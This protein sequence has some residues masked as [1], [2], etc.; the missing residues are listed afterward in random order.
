[1]SRVELKQ[2]IEENWSKSKFI[3]LSLN[4]N[5]VNQI[6]IAT[7]FLNE[8]YS[9]IP[10]RT[11]A[12]VII[13]NLSKD[14]LPKCFCG[15]CAAINTTYPDQGFRLYCGSE[16]ARKDKTIHKNILTLLDDYTFLY[17]EKI[18][19]QKSIEQI[20]KELNISITP[21]IKHLKKHNL[22]QLNDARRRNT[23]ANLL[24]KN[25]DQLVS[26]YETNTLEQIAQTA[27][28]TKATVSRWFK[29]HQIETKPS[30]SYERKIKRIS[31]E[32]NTLYQYIKSI[33]DGEIQ[34][35]N[36]SI[37]NGKE[38]DILIPAKNIA[39]EYNGL[40]SHHYRPWEEKECLIKNSKYHL[41]KTLECEKRGVQLLQFYSDEWNF[42]RSI[43]ESIIRSKLNLNKRIYARNCNIIDVT[44]YDK[45]NFL[46]EFHFQGEDKSSIKLGLIYENDLVAIMT[47]A[48]S[49]FNRAYDWE[50]TRFCVKSGISVTGGFSKLLKAFKESH[51]GSIISYAD[52]RY[53]N[54]NVYLK[55]GFKL[56]HINS[57]SYYYVDKNFLRRVNR[58]RF[59]KKIIGAYECTEYEKA[60]EMGFEKIWDCGTLVYGL[61]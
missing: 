5:K 26:L 20:A 40:Y 60:R 59:Q 38:L 34:Q 42:K 23:K 32:E 9:K 45:N 27:G 54:G 56:L 2:V 33:Y 4:K 1:M 13:K 16:C 29:F 11:R 14:S 28:T 50:L 53:S 10:L 58:M 37:L 15:K 43:V 47:F 12:Y 17:E 46:N 7:S 36:R 49:R 31:N 6:T 3:S 51:N 19:K 22:Y 30:N 55:N 44:T 39:I 41:N 57:P 48:K 18:I 21:V 25:K 61:N 8:I 24:L 35:S 52:R